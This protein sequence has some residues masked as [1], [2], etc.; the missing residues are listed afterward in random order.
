MPKG[1][2][3]KVWKRTKKVNDKTYKF[4]HATNSKRT[5]KKTAKTQRKKGFGA[6]VESVKS[7][8]KSPRKTTSGKHAI[9]IRKTGV[10]NP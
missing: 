10:Q 8:R 2:K 5:A 7:K 3:L 4:H 1:K 9:Y 6:V